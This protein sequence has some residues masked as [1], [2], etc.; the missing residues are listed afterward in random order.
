MDNLSI[1]NI[2]SHRQRHL[3]AALMGGAAMPVLTATRAAS[4]APERLPVLGTMPELIGLTDWFNGSPL[5]RQ[6]LMGKVVVVEFWALGCI[7]CRHALPHVAAWYERYKDQGLVVVG[8]HAPEFD[9]ERPVQAV[10]QAAADMKLGFPIALDN[11]FRTWNAFRNA[12]WPAAYFV[13]AQGRIRH[14][15]YG[16]G[17]YEQGERVIQALLSERHGQGAPIKGAWVDGGGHARG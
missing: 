16:E 14:R 7:N 13:D 2:L 12:Y 17:A 4:A 10:R 11:D 1:S 9:A 6:Q 15:R 5:S 8:V 3:L